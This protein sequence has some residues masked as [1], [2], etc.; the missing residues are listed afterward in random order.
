MTNFLDYIHNNISKEY[1]YFSDEL[2]LV[3]DYAEDFVKENTKEQL[4]KEIETIYKGIR[5]KRT[6]NNNDAKDKL[7][8]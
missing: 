3:Y 7:G 5:I 2:N 4:V 6:K 1:V 8:R